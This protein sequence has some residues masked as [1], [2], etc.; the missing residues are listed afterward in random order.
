[1]DKELDH[2]L[3]RIIDNATGAPNQDRGGFNNASVEPQPAEWS[4]G[5]AP[6][7]PGQELASFNEF[8]EL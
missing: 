4:F 3:R 6:R 1:M 8:G 5:P 2:Q 7:H